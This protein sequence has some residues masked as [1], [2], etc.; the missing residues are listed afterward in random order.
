M[1]G[2]VLDCCTLL[3]LYCGWGGVQNLR[4]IAP[5]F[6]LGQRVAAELLF[7]RDFDGDGSLIEQKLSKDELLRQYRFSTLKLSSPMEEDLMVRLATKLDDGE[8]EGLALA[9]CRGLIFCSDDK[10]VV[11]AARA[12]GLNTVIVSTPE[13]LQA[14]AGSHAHR[15]SALP[16]IVRRVSVLGRFCPH[17]SSPHRSWWEQQRTL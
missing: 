8:A 1:T 17:R 2:Y 9:S 12:E 15:T 6:H 7:V 13:L 4:D 14:W 16:D 10:P 5:P 11:E 3:N